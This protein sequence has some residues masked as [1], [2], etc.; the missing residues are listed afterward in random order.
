MAYKQQIFTSH[1]SGGGEV[2][3]QVLANWL[4]GECA[5]PGSRTAFFPPTC[6]HRVEGE[7]EL[8]GVSIIKAL[9]LFMR[10]EPPEGPTF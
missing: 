4:S 5:L 6:P 8:S 7:K 1:S 2:Q 3:D 10:A 9:M